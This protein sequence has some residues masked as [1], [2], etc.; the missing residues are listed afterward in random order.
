MA[1]WLAASKP[2]ERT[3]AAK[4]PAS[5]FDPRR[6][7]AAFAERAARRRLPAKAAGV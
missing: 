5:L 7:A 6:L 2:L 4:A 3:L 1:A